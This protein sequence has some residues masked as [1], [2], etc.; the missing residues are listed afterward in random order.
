[1]D[2]VIPALAHLDSYS[3][4]LRTGWSADNVRGKAAADEE[5]VRIAADPAG[6]VASL[7]D[8]GARG[9]DI[10]L[11]D[12]STARRLPGYRLFMWDA[13][14]FCG[15]IGLRW[16][17]G[18]SALPPHVLGHIGYAVVPWKRRQGHATRALGLMLAH[19]RGE[20]LG[21]VLITTT[22][23]NTPSQKV[24]QAHGGVL[25]EQFTVPDTH[26]GGT[27]LRYRVDL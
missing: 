15:S 22:P 2:L 24:I 6:F 26:G 23:Q 11:P 25:V 12:G 19:A 16:Q 10:V 7:V 20:G 18:T 1:M 13:G 4:A 27:G 17:P 8:R 9:G 5:L 21:Q 14:D 3:A